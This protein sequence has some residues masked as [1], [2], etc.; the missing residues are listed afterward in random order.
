M[1]IQLNPKESMVIN[2]VARA[3]EKLGMET[4][5][6]GGFVRDKILGRETKDADFVCVGDAIALAK[7][8]AKE[9]KPVPTVDVYK[10][11]G[12]AH[13]NIG[14]GVDIEFVGARKESYQRDSRKPEVEPGTVK[15]D[16]DRRD[17]TINALAISLNK[18]DYGKLVDP[19]E[20]LKDLEAGIIRTPLKPSETF[21]DDPLRM[22]RA[23]RFAT[24]LNFTI[25]EKT[26]QGI[27]ETKER[28]SI[29]SQERITDELNKVIAAEQPSIGF[30]LLFKCGLLQIIFP[31]MAELAG[32]EYKDGHGHKDNFYHTL[33]VLDNLSANT[34]DP[35]LRWS[36]LLHDIA[37]PVTKK[38]E[39]GHGWTFHGHEVV[40][41]RM[42]PK[43]FA[44]L[45]LPQNEKMRFVRKM[46]ELHLRPISLTK[47]NITDS[48]IRR[49][50]FDAGEDFDALML[51]CEADITSK[52]KQ[53]V[54]RY[55]ENFKLVRQRCKEV[56]EKDHIRNWQPPV[57]GEM[58]MQAFGLPPSKPVG[59]IKDAL[60]DAILD[61]VIPN[62]Y[63]AAYT[64]MIEK[65]KSLG[66]V[67]QNRKS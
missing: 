23:I 37:K 25:E 64:Y 52:N 5:L 27:L 16:Q 21:S 39:E 55:L 19:F 65:G 45:K 15:D 10:N 26:W 34:D 24:Q 17:F 67:L 60:K 48:A 7:Q 49:L 3:A 54:K 46:V 62:T 11:F 43:I 38:F 61:G 8:V 22:L 32:T 50:L 14:G 36:A 33:Q 41:G 44:K 12:T 58:I 31:Q 28:I 59:V 63:D 40:G 35:W 20:G 30:D 47:E 51:L 66:L 53:K 4:Y 13:I 29:I 18:K 9:F 56:E 6:I 57:T 42:V 1:D 2:N